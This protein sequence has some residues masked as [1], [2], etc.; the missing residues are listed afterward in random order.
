V[1]ENA[2]LSLNVSE[3]ALAFEEDSKEKAAE[4]YEED[5]MMNA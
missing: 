5:D 4:D 3:L 2:S 1:Y